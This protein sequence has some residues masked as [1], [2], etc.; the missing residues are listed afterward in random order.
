MRVVDGFYFG[1]TSI[2]Y[3]ELAHGGWNEFLLADAAVLQTHLAANALDHVV[4]LQVDLHN[5][6]LHPVRQ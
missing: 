3:S 5:F 2:F 4:L 1:E 6:G